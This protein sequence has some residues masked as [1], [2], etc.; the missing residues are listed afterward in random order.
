MD[1]FL[2]LV[3]GVDDEYSRRVAVQNGLEVV[4]YKP[5]NFGAYL[6]AK[7]AV[8]LRKTRASQTLR[9]DAAATR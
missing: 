8:D 9:V 6:E 3:W 5:T 2:R 4:I 7:R 1:G